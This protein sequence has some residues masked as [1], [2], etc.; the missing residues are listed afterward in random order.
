MMLKKENW[1]QY[2]IGRIESSLDA[3]DQAYLGDHDIPIDDVQIALEE[4]KRYVNK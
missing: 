1:V 2:Q 4:L 3:I